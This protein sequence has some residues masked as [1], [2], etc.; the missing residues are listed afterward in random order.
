MQFTM[1]VLADLLLEMCRGFL[2]AQRS[3]TK[4]GI[5]Q[6]LAFKISQFEVSLQAEAQTTD[7]S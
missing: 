6:K 3:K 4:G 5:P 7:N 2:I 1:I